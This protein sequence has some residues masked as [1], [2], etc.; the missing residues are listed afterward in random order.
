[1]DKSLGTILHFCD[2][3]HFTQAQPLPSPHKQLWTR[4][5]RSFSLFRLCGKTA[6]KFRK[7]ALF[8][9]GSQKLQ[10]NMNTA[11]LSQGLL[12]CIVT[13]PQGGTGRIIYYA[14]G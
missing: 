8:Y 5:S 14:K 10:K 2:V 6:K 3:V 11:L 12:S 9:E 13:S 4:I 1:M 7:V